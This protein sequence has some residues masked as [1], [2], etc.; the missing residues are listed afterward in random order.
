MFRTLK[1][2][3][4]L[5]ME[6]M[7]RML[8]MWG[9]WRI[10]HKGYALHRAPPPGITKMDSWIN[11]SCFESDIVFFKMWSYERSWTMY[12]YSAASV[13]HQTKHF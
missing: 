3:G 6:R 1:M 9:M 2:L 13:T 7:W 10:C 4:M 11:K 8:R 12:V 5:R